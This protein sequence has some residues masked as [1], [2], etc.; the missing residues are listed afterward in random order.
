MADVPGWFDFHPLYD[1]AVATAPR[2]SLLIE[3]GVFHGKSLTYL[4]HQAKAADKGLVVVGV[5]WGRGSEEH[6]HHAATLPAGNLAGVQLRNLLTAGIADDTVLLIAPSALAARIIPD[7]SAW[8]VFLDGD[9]SEMGVLADIEAWR[10][11]VMP[12]GMMAGHD[13]FA[14]P[15]VRNAVHHV[16][17]RLDHISVDTP[18][19]WEVRL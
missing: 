18:S 3:I 7:Q 14:F 16:F 13:Y 9:H 11:K 8:M 17:G 6:G 12:G 4:A 5:D 19:C 1:R 10:P 2:N 15:G